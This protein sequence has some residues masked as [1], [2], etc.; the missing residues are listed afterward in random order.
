VLALRWGAVVYAVAV[1]ALALRV[2]SWDDVVALAVCVFITTFRTLL[3]LT[4][5]DENPVSWL[6]ALVDVLVFSIAAGWTGATESP[7]VFCA[8]AAVVV[9]SFGWG[10][11]FAIAGV[12]VSIGGVLL[13]LAGDGNGFDAVAGS[14]RDY[15]LAAFLICAAAGGAFMRSRLVEAESRANLAS[16]ELAGL[17]NANELLTE[18]S[19][20]ALTLPGSFT[21]REAIEQIRGRLREILQPEVIALLTLDE[22]Q[23]EW[24]PKIADRCAMRPAGTIA[25]LPEPLRAAAAGEVVVRRNIAEG[26]ARLSE[27]SR[28]GMYLPLRARGR[29]VGV[30][31]VEHSRPGHFDRVDSTLREGLADVIALTIDNARWFGRLRTL[32]AEEERI[33]VARD[34]HDRLGQWMTY[35]KLE[36][37]RIARSEDVDRSELDRLAGDASTAVDELRETLRQL[38]TGVSDDRPLAVLGSELVAGFAARTQVDARFK[39]TNP[40]QRLPV[41]IENELLRIIQ[42]ALNNVQRHARAEHVR[43]EWTVD[44]GNFELRVTDDGRGFDRT[45]AVRDQAYGVVGMRER[46]DVIGATF[47]IDSSPGHGTRVIVGAGQVRKPAEEEMP[48]AGPLERAT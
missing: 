25:E 27:Q 8:M 26:A 33:R 15:V 20:V 2:A 23:D 38:R 39:A 43:V 1:E 47:R 32:G 45:K 41:P 9:A 5:G 40:G 13:G 35:M 16:G 34:I 14:G 7:W 22:H 10:P 28:S 19:G 29:L 37:E 4:L 12:L 36:I 3:P 6:G 31:G 44:G 30:I 46:A 21:L 24:S 42:E 18:L 11:W 17:V 48:V